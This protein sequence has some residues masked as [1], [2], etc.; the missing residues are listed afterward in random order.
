VTLGT[1]RYRHGGVV[2]V[3]SSTC[4]GDVDLPHDTDFGD[5]AECRAW[6]EKVWAHA[7]VREA[8]EMASPDLATRIGQLLNAT[9]PAPSARGLRRAALSVASY[10]VRW[11][12]RVT[13]FGLFAG[14]LPATVGPALTGGISGAHRIAVR[15]DSEWIH[16]L[17][18]RLIG[19]DKLWTLLTIVTDNAVIER[20]GRFIILRRASTGALVPGPLREVSVRSTRP[21]R[22][23]LAAA[24]TPVKVSVLTAQLAARF[25]HAPA[26]TIATMLREL[27]GQGFLITN[28]QPPMTSEDPLQYLAS[29][30]AS[31][32]ARQLP[33]ISE[34][35]D[36]LGQ[37]S[38]G[39]SLPAASAIGMCGHVLA[40]DVRLGGH[41]VLPENVIA[42]AEAAASVLLR[43]T[44]RPFGSSA[45]LNYHARFRARY[46]PGALVPVRDLVADSGLGYPAGYLGATA[47]TP[48]WRTLTERD[49]AL[50]TLIQHTAMTGA[51]EIRLSETDITTLTVGDHTAAIAPER[52]E[53]GV[54]VR[55]SSA[56][57]LADGHFELQVTAAPR[58]PTSMADRFAYL[59][60]EQER[61]LLAAT[62]KASPGVI[63][64]Q[65]SF[66]PRRPHNENVVRVAPLLPAIM[67]LSEHPDPASAMIGVDDL[68]VTAD[69]EQMYLVQRSTG[70]RVIPHVPHALDTV[71]Q[72]PP[73]AR[74]IAEVADARSAVFGPLDLGAARALPYVP[75]L[76]YR[77][78]VLSRAR[79]LLASSDL[80]TSSGHRDWNDRLTQWRRQHRVPSRVI[81]CHGELRL[82]LDLDQALDRTL[83]H[84]SLGRNERVEL[85]ED[86]LEGA[87]GWIGRP[88]ELLIPMTLD[89][90]PSRP[91]PRTAPPGRAGTGQAT[92]QS[93]TRSWPAIRP[94]STT[95]SPSTC[96]GSCKRWPCP[97]KG[98][99]YAATGI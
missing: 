12:R 16:Q 75:R 44:T 48:T 59:L 71:V 85:R 18:T 46:G 21:V 33:G 9:A 74:F 68:A 64:V 15:A 35:L 29:Q 89:S 96:R 50:L 72:G 37:V 66:P 17:I 25:P 2:L 90:P 40:A 92:H 34:L 45:W 61:S 93:C 67:P 91:L 4:R 49:S 30:L 10:L 83:L 41:L 84:T 82:P 98:G 80:K 97:R 5:P 38:A 28:L 65:L 99:G 27:T 94:G 60:D 55:A 88:A 73:L 87:D 13:P 79:W 56:Q 52:V 43:L 54:T 51:D 22:A 57:S 58:T 31:C 81:M 3:R 32:G 36:E 7:D 95:S 20:D 14:I 63:A 8:V 1:P 77:R 24:A 42:E 47:A 86:A 69:A 53:I 6:L 11:E 70:Y 62:Y 26:E 76:R 23:A 19:D 78:T 39:L